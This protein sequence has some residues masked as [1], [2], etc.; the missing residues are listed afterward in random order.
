MPAGGSTSHA[1]GKTILSN[2]DI[3]ATAG[4]GFATTQTFNVFVA[5]GTLNL[6]FTSVLNNAT[7]GAIQIGRSSP[8]K[9]PARRRTCSHPAS[10]DRRSN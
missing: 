5:D 4:K 8:P 1:E 10:P 7:L 3:V 2:F 9:A 6:V